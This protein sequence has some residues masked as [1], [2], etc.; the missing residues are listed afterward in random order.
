MT[1]QASQVRI[2][3]LLQYTAASAGLQ[4]LFLRGT[5][6]YQG[7]HLMFKKKESKV[8][9]EKI[10]QFSYLVLSAALWLFWAQFEGSVP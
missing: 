6:M 5:R 9:F 10:A 1:S 7:V 4:W 3:C 2:V 8:S